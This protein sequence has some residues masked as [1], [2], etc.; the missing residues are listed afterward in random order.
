MS[1]NKG[2]TERLLGKLALYHP[3]PVHPQTTSSQFKVQYE[4]AKY[5]TY[6][7]GREVE[8]NLGMGAVLGECLGGR[9]CVCGRSRGRKGQIRGNSRP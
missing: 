4:A 8:H 9:D 3:M 2:L 1:M 7:E 6:L 5:L